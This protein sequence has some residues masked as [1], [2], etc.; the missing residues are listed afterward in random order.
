MY[1]V[2]PVDWLSKL[3]YLLQVLAFALAISAIQF[4]FQPDTPYDIPMRYSL[5]IAV[6][7]WAIIDF[8]R[9]YFAS[10][11]ETGWPLGWQ[12]VALSMGGIVVGYVLGTLLADIWCGWPGMSFAV[13]GHGQLRVSIL[14]TA[15]AGVAGTYYFY[16]VNKSAYL[17]AQMRQATQQ[18]AES[19][20]KLLESQLEPHMVFNTLANLRA[21]IGV[22]SQRAQTM[23]DH[24]IAYLRATLGAS[25]TN[26]H[27]LAQE[28]DRL[29]DYLELMAVRMGPR[30]QYTLSLSDTLCQHPVPPLLLQPLVENCIIHGLEPKVEGGSI[31]VAARRDGNMVRLDVLDTGLG[32]VLTQ[33][34]P[35][36]TTPGKGFGLRQ[37]RERLATLYGGDAAMTF[38]ADDAGGTRASVTFPFNP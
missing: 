10:S 16:S 27:T 36:G 34:T 22:D 6:C 17:L 32:F 9:H 7:T 13:P 12:G 21:L 29:R 25:Q 28:F 8:G 18:A 35:P 23:L 1:L 20:L 2:T 31:T 24:L 3:R 5:C 19:R 4:A 11:A 15:I 30:L 14:I 37:V 38:I 33:G 26:T